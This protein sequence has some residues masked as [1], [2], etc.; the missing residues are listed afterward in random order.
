MV[1]FAG[2][3]ADFHEVIVGYGIVPH[4]VLTFKG[5]QN[6]KMVR[7]DRQLPTINFGTKMSNGLLYGHYFTP[8]RAP[9]LLCR[10]QMFTKKAQGLPSV[11][12]ELLQHA[13]DRAGGGVAGQGEGL[14]RVGVDQ[15]A[16]A[17]Q[18]LLG[19]VEMLL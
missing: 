11:P 6:W 4:T 8:K 2:P 17:Q 1:N 7:K 9:A 5:A 12:I 15:L 10:C 14:G 18:H 16:G 19:H 3:I 13:A